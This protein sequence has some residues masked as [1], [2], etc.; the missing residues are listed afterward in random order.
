MVKVRFPKF[1]VQE[2]VEIIL[3]EVCWETDPPHHQEVFEAL[4]RALILCDHFGLTS[5]SPDIGKGSIVLDLPTNEAGDA[6][7][8]GHV[9]NLYPHG[10]GVL[11]CGNCGSTSRF[12]VVS[13]KKPTWT[14]IEDPDS[15]NI[16]QV[17]H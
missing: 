11:K 5:V 13:E 4:E 15:S 16:I 17:V 9:A 1:Y 14:H 2:G 6:L 3:L 8:I 7:H 12:A 10:L